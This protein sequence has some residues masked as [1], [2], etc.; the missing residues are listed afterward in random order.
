MSS[1][2]VADKI[3]NVVVDPDTLKAAVSFLVRNLGRLVAFTDRN[4]KN[5]Q[6]LQLAKKKVDGNRLSSLDLRI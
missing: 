5:D 4:I 2:R 3:V 1:E 6:A